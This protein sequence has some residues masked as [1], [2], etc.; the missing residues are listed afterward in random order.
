[1][2]DLTVGKPSRVILAFSLPLLLSTALQQIYNLADS[3]IVGQLTGEAGLAAIGAGYPITLVFVAV[4][5]GASMGCSVTI[6]GL[7]GGKEMA[8]VKAAASTVLL[9]LS[10]LAVVLAAAGIALATPILRLL[11]ASEELLES[12]SVYLRIYALGVIPMMLFNIVSAVYTG[13][14]DSKRPLLF[15]AISSGL[16]IVL[17]YLAVGPLGM[18]VAGAAW[19]TV[20]AQAVSGVLSGATLLRRLRAIPEKAERLFD[21]GIFRSMMGLAVPAMFQQASVALGHTIVQSLVNTFDTAVVAGYEISNKLNTVIYS[22]MNTLGTAMSSYVA[23]CRGAKKYARIREGTRVSILMCLVVAVVV[24]LLGQLLPSQIMGLFVSQENQ[25]VI[26]VGVNYL[27]IITP[28]YFLITMIVTTGG[29]LRGME[30]TM[31]F[32]LETLAEFAVRI[33][34]C[35]VLVAVL[36][37]YVGVMWAWYFGSSVGFILCTILYFRTM[38]REV[39]PNCIGAVKQ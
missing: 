10:V 36:D 20:V 15:L 7:F 18:G 39:R 12:A 32:F 16:N 13:L 3:A 37:S 14:G 26:E 29:L 27:R 19:A 25:A 5:T 30:H 4:A 17:D 11:N 8:K 34:M 38:R 33:C 6:S 9:S 31:T 21:W 24:V 23:Q 35:Y 2:K 1:M 28:V 22:C